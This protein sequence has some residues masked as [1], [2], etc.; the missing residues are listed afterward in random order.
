MCGFLRIGQTFTKL[1]VELATV[2]FFVINTASIC[3][4]KVYITPGVLTLLGISHH[5]YLVGKDVS[6]IGNNKLTWEVGFSASFLSRQDNCKHL[7]CRSCDV[8]TSD[9]HIITGVDP[10]SQAND[11]DGKEQ[12]HHVSLLGRL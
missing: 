5:P 7:G 6:E 11:E 10:A 8:C 1:V 4:S 3:L 2:L 9:P 12:S